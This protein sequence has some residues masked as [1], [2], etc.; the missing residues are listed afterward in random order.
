[1]SVK[2][3]ARGE[4][5]RKLIL[6]C[7]LELIERS[8]IEAVT[9]R[10]VGEEC[11][12]PLGSV[13]YYFPTRDELLRE[14]LELW[15]DEEVERLSAV[16]EAITAEGL[17][18]SEGAARWG[19]L[20]RGNDPHQASQFELYLHASRTPEL[21]E[22]AAQAFAAYERVAAAALRAAGLPAEDA[23]ESAALFVALAD[24][25]G[26]RRLAEPGARA[27]FDDALVR[28]FDGLAGGSG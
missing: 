1:M 23:A 16:A 6:H 4:E 26:L 10:A 11:G 3:Q 28:L 7:T 12:V 8:G 19:E 20:L 27:A 13:T 22:A 18:P 5:R 17:S 25:M 2:R 24:G 21:R 9:H 15:V 14:A